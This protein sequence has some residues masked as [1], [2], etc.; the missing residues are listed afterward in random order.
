M[1]ERKPSKEEKSS[2]T[3]R[4]FARM[5][6]CALDSGLGWRDMRHMKYTHL[7]QLLFE[8]EDMRGAD[9]DEV[10]EGTKENMLAIARL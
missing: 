3:S 9:V 10:R 5:A 8:W 6:L 7:M 2:P 1:P 4:P